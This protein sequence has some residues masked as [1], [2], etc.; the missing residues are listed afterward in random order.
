MNLL[1]GPQ[2]YVR[3]FPIMALALFLVGCCCDDC[4]DDTMDNFPSDMHHLNDPNDM[5]HTTSVMIVED[6]VYVVPDE[7]NDS[8]PDEDCVY[9]G[10]NQ[11]NIT[12]EMQEVS[13]RQI[14]WMKRNPGLVIIVEGHC[15]ERG[16]REY[17]LALG[18]RRAN[19]VKDYMIAHG[20]DPSRIET[21][22]YGKDRPLMLGSTSEA[23]SQNR[24]SVS[25]VK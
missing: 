1:R 22:S 20:I 6:D 19:G 9:Y 2:M 17:N 3:I 4:N 11:H 10:T 7:E 16:T 8:F 25:V 21:I 24:V 15:D 5:H 12:P 14:D 23:W 18:E 13:D